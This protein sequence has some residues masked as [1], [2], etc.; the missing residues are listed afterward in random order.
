MKVLH[1]YDEHYRV[2][3]GQ[4]SVSSI[5][6]SLARA[7][8]ANGHDVTVLE[9]Q[10]RGLSKYEE[11]EGVAF[12]RFRLPIG[13]NREGEEIPYREIRNPV[14]IARLLADRAHFA[15]KLRRYLSG[16]DFD[17]LH[18]HLPFTANVL[19][20]LLPEIR[21]RTVYTA[22]V[23]EEKTRFDIGANSG[24]P[25]P[26]KLLTPDLHLMKRVARS[27]VLNDG[28]QTVLERKGIENTEV[29]PN[30]VSVSE[31]EVEAAKVARVM[32][33]YALG[34]IVVLF[35]GTI[36]PQK[37]IDVLVE[38]AT[39]VAE[40]DVGAVNF[41]LVGDDALDENYA[42]RVKDDVRTNGLGDTVEFAGYV[43]FEDLRAL[44]AAAD[45]FVLPSRE[46]GMPM[47]L[48]EALAAGAP[49]VGTDVGGIPM[50][51]EDGANGALV[52]P[53]DPEELAD[54][55]LALADDSRKRRRMGERSREIAEARYGWDAI[56]ERYLD[57]YEEVKSAAS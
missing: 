46:E 7:T 56:A 19:I 1:L 45:I 3:M 41:L 55:I 12:R 8:A 48:L 54:R 14:G 40:R 29:V 57:V 52:E 18:V 49:L 25:L 15:V 44:Y 22:H 30:G 31:F 51:I 21:E 32:E 16:A 24:A 38:A 33:E 10:W 35:V 50:L 53:E 5:V 4:G 23:G 42:E 28:A 43:P 17:V 2:G 26:M 20:H 39:L 11:S 34:G 36:T 37:G 13:S 6:F 47:V 27:V 9:R